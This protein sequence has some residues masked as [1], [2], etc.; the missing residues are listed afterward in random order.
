MT[1]EMTQLGELNSRLTSSNAKMRVPSNGCRLNEGR[2][3]WY[4]SRKTQR[5]NLS[6]SR[7]FIIQ[8]MERLMM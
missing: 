3:G 2:G 5:M 7:Q 8:Y 1:I 4:K 6:V